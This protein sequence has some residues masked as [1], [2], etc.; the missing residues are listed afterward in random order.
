MKEVLTTAQ[1]EQFIHSGYVAIN[2]AFSTSLAEECREILW[3]D[4]PVSK[5]NAAT[6]TQPVIRLGMYQQ[7][8]FL[9]SANT[10]V[11]HAAFNQLVGEG[12]WMPCKSMGTF[13]VR[14]PSHQDPGD[15]GWHVDVSFPGD[16]PADYFSWRSNIRSR[17]RALLMLFL[18][19]DVGENDAPTRL[20]QGSHMD[21]ARVLKDKGS[22][23]FTFMELAEQLPGLPERPIVTATGKAGTVYLCHPFM[24]HAAQAHRGNA[25][26][27]MAQ[28]PL[29]LHSELNIEVSNPK[30]SP[31]EQSII[32][33]CNI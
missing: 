26:K 33:G 8:A 5:D 22:E 3:K 28:P 15:T 16:N 13:P 21:I 6:W 14:F 7:D 31:L 19:S 29:L 32:R 18:Y 17:G 11:L 2:N 24:V 23:G 9:Q 12:N 1:V 10:Q 25:P 27:F 30:P 4:L 20:M